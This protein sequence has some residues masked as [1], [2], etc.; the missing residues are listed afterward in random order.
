MLGFKWHNYEVKLLREMTDQEIIDVFPKSQVES[1]ISIKKPEA[2]Y[3]YTFD[4]YIFS[5]GNVK[6]GNY[7]LS[8][9][10]PLHNKWTSIPTGR[11]YIGSLYVNPIIG[12]QNPP[13]TVII[14]TI[15]VERA[16]KVLYKEWKKQFAKSFTGVVQGVYNL[17]GNLVIKDKITVSS[18]DIVSFGYTLETY[19]KLQEHPNTSILNLGEYARDCGEESINQIISVIQ[20]A[21]A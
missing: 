3:T 11:F 13:D 8:D 16:H 2:T 12:G 14:D 10:Q 18:S 9:K 17:E 7:S 1:C 5:G 21:G 4:G 20:S 15:G 19:Y 6:A